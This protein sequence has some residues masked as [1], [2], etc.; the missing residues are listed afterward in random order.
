ML[1]L[2]IVRYNLFIQIE[3][4]AESKT[5]PQDD[6]LHD[7]SILSVT[8]NCFLGVKLKSERFHYQFVFYRWLCHF[9]GFQLMLT[10]FCCFKAE[11][12]TK[13]EGEAEGEFCDLT[14]KAESVIYDPNVA[15]GE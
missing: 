5:V 12:D 4:G 3:N 2:S 15:I 11:D 6:A 8:V 1:A 13:M 7:V 9:G 14:T 10:P